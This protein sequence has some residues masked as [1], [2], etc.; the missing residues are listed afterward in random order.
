MRDFS[1]GKA[2]KNI[3]T[4][5]ERILQAKWLAGSLRIIWHWM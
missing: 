2:F 3:I 5:K 1:G 4:K